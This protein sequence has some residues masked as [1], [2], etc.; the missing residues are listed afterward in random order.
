[1]K[2]ITHSDVPRDGIERSFGHR[3]WGAFVMLAIFLAP[4]FLPEHL[5]ALAKEI[6]DMPWWIWIVAGPILLIVF[7]IYLFILI[8]MWRY[9]TACFRRTNCVM[10]LSF[11]GVYLQFRSYLNHHFPD[12]GPTVVFLPW[13][14][15]TACQKT[16]H[17]TKGT[18]SDGDTVT[19]AARYLDLHLKHT[20]TEA[21]RKAIAKETARKRQGKERSKMRFHHAPVQVPEP[22]VVRVEWRGSKMLKALQSQVTVRPQR[23]TG[24]GHDDTDTP[25]DFDAQIISMIEQ[26]EHMPAVRTARHH[27]GMSLSEAR[28]FVDDLAQSRSE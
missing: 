18:D 7:L 23:R 25:I 14:E 26:G 16:I 1:M 22:G 9:V 6:L 21:L 12:E 4:V 27:Y 20:D 3:S 10:K 28:D 19:R 13:T 11:E 15:I 24:V 8:A 5:G 17:H 2:L